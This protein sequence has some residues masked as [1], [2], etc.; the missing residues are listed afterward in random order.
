MAGAAYSYS[1]SRVGLSDVRNHTGSWLV[2][3]T[4]VG[5]GTLGATDS[6][7][8]RTSLA[9]NIVVPLTGAGANTPIAPGD[10][11]VGATYMLDVVKHY[12]RIKVTALSLRVVPLFPSTTNSTSV[13]IAPQRGSSGVGTVATDTTAMLPYQNVLSMAGSKQFAS[14]EAGSIDMTS[15]IAGGSGAQQNEFN[16]ADD[17]NVASALGSY[18]YVVA[19]IV[20]ATFAVSGNNSTTAVRGTFLHALIADMKFDLIDFIG[21]DN[22]ATPFGLYRKQSL[23]ERKALSSFD[24]RI[25]KLCH[26]LN[27]PKDDS[28]DGKEK[29]P[30]D[31]EKKNKSD[32][33]KKPVSA[34]EAKSSEVVKSDGSK[35]LAT[36]TINSSLLSGSP[37]ADSLTTDLSR[38]QILFKMGYV[39]V[40]PPD[41]LKRQ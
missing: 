3:Y 21:G 1:P 13:I 24:D 8:M 28:K 18:G 12:A 37:D 36:K 29:A 4:Y 35:N 40:D 26:S 9:A 6:V 5:N 2:G 22:E 7:Y 17:A 34:F 33:D 30:E 10:S 23:L 20:P 39:K 25:L 14:W 31:W 16:I 11:L 27:F 41:Q 15:C 32:K 38:S 19:G